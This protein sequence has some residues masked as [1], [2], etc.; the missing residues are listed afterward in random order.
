MPKMLFFE[1]AFNY[2]Q[3]NGRKEKNPLS[4]KGVIGLQEANMYFTQCM[5]L[6]LLNIL[7][8][9]YVFKGDGVQSGR[10]LRW[11]ALISL[12]LS[13]LQVSLVIVS[14]FAYSNW[15]GDGD[16]L[17]D[18]G[19][20]WLVYTG[21]MSFCTASAGIVS[22][23]A[24]KRK[25]SKGMKIAGWLVCIVGIVGFTRMML[26]ALV[27]ITRYRILGYRGFH[28]L[29]EK[30]R[31]VSGIIFWVA[32]LLLVIFVIVSLI[33]NRKK[34][35]ISMGHLAVSGVVCPKCGTTITEG[36]RFCRNCGTAVSDD[37]KEV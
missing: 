6:F 4:S 17:S 27:K 24:A 21:C 3:E 33:Q 26:G 2:T 14:M 15:H 11:G 16:F 10:L 29:D 7:L 23:L 1:A 5:G 34:C 37:K 19:S 9:V 20:V 13:L 31:A 8:M 28:S 22:L 32:F 25:K 35:F 18:G 30:V 36:K 12:I